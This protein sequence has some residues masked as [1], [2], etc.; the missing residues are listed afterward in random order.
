M[1]RPRS[2][3]GALA[4][5]ALRLGAAGVP[6]FPCRP[7]DKSPATAHGVLDATTD[8][9]RIAA[10]WA[11]APGCNVAIATGRPGPDVLDVDVAD[12]WDAAGVLERLAGAGLLAGA[13]TVV[14]TRNGGRHFYYPGTEHPCRRLPRVHVDFKSTGGYVLAP[15]SWVPPSRW[16][17]K[18]RRPRFP[19]ADGM[20]RVL[21]H[22]PGPGRPLSWAHVSNL[23]DPP[24]PVQ[25]H[26]QPVRSHSR[27][28]RAVLRVLG[29][30]LGPDGDRSAA[31]HRLVRTAWLVGCTDA[32]IHEIA[33]E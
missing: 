23:L 17:E 12:G 1:D 16:V 32:D 19:A 18:L 13:V 22:R 33:S 27:W 9:E 26:R 14:A 2:D 11:A 15:P 8:A 4:A 29:N 10:W 6:V 31:L 24:A 20:Y 7:G 30:P 28:P 25:V 21:K 3:G 5:A